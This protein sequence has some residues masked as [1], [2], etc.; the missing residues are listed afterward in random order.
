[1]IGENIKRYR[2][3]KKMTQQELADKLYVT[4][5]AV[6]RWEKNEV[7]PSIATITKMSQIFG[8]STDDILGVEKKEEPVK[9][10]ETKQAPVIERVII[11]EVE[12]PVEKRAQIGVC[13]KCNKPIYEG[14][15]SHRHSHSGRG[16]S[17]SYVHCDSCEQKLKAQA[18]ENKRIAQRKGRIKGW[19]WGSII[20][21]I[22]ISVG[23]VLLT[24]GSEY[25]VSGIAAI[26]L[27][28]LAWF[29]VACAFLNNNPAAEILLWFM[30]L[31]IFKMPGFIISLDFGSI[32]WMILVKG[33]LW[34]F[35]IILVVICTILGILIAGVFGIFAYPFALRKSYKH[36]E[37]YEG[38]NV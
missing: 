38:F 9:E 32:I 37:L 36:P 7:E 23:I 5:Q 17:H 34:I 3:E 20:A 11:K 18:L 2:N 19:V 28:V 10:E 29:A 4:A 26:V 24:L 8:V 12:K 31:G 14:E 1:M 30:G 21:A 15:V 33:L 6:S 25:T 16:Y 13:E 27:G 35:E 22:L